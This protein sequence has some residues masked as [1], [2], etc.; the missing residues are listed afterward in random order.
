MVT[1]ASNMAW[2]IKPEEEMEK[3]MKTK[4]L[5]L[6][7]L[8]GVAAMSANAGV[9]FGV[10]VAVPQPVVV[11]TPVVC[12]AYVTPTPTAVV[13][14]IPPCPGVDYVWAPGYWTYHTNA[15]VW[16]SGAWHYRPAHAVFGYRHGGYRR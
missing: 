13:E 11:S 6:A 2:A 8:L 3:N 7:A 15:R 16:V 14:T 1:C 5:V 12:A 4:M 9:R 10:T